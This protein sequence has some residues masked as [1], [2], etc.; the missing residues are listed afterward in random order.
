MSSSEQDTDRHRRVLY[1]R[2]WMRSRL[3]REE[4]VLKD[5][6]WLAISDCRGASHYRTAW[7]AVS[8]FTN[9]DANS[10]R[11]NQRERLAIFAYLKK[12]RKY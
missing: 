4:N 5:A 11:P 12:E 8:S 1:V 9:S 3:R 7:P 2:P 10:R 6:D